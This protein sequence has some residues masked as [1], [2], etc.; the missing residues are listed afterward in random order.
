MQYIGRFL[1]KTKKIIRGRDDPE[2]KFKI[3]AKKNKE[4]FNES[5]QK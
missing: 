1:K 4:L 2:F 5:N 3:A